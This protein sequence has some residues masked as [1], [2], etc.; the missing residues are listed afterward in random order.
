[1]PPTVTI[2]KVMTWEPMANQRIAQP[3]QAVDQFEIQEAISS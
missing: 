1:M 2:G 3:N